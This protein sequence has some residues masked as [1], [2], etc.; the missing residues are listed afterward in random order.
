M[1]KGRGIVG[2]FNS[3][4]IGTNDREAGL[5][6]CQQVAGV[7]ENKLTQDVK[8]RWR[9]S[10]AMCNSLRINQEA[11]LIFDIRNQNAAV[12]FT[13]N[14]LSLED[15]LINDQT[16]ALLAPLAAASQ[17]LEGKTYPTSNL[18]L[19]SIY[20]CIEHVNP[21]QRIA[22]PWDGKMLQHSEL[23][24]EVQEARQA[25]F[26]DLVDRWKTNIPVSRKR[27]YLTA[28]LL[29]PRQKELKI[30]GLTSTEK[31][32]AREWLISEY[33]SLWERDGVGGE[34][35]GSG[36]SNQNAPAAAPN[37]PPAAQWSFIHSVSVKLCPLARIR[38]SGRWQWSGGDSQEIRG[39][40]VLS[41]PRGANVH[42]YFEVVASA[43]AEVPQPEQDGTPVSGLPCHLSISREAI[44]H[45]GTGLR[46][47]APKHGR[48][49]T[50]GHHVWARI[51]CAGR[52]GSWM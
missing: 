46:R 18:V 43:R 42:R 11:L 21:A 20:S 33:V 35:S 34:A 2:Y 31:H 28:T 49:D 52:V 51:N 14:R 48:D 29:D 12:S 6:K 23:R 32:E 50:G 16:V 19:P 40:G 9:S 17:Y 30:P 36:G 44:Q 15:W 27:Y 47:P 1:E 39:R 5:K 22:Q 4:V 41:P 13:N 45:R 10:H 38:W 24:P 3:S 7:P 25:L 8:T 26:D 37:Q